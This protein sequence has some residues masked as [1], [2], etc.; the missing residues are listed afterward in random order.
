MNNT[1][2]VVQ[3]FYKTTDV[4]ID[5]IS[6]SKYPDSVSSTCAKDG[7]SYCHL[8]KTIVFLDVT[9]TEIDITT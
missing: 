7:Y 5:F 6:I 4:Q 2:I 9:G 3:Y 8:P 1:A